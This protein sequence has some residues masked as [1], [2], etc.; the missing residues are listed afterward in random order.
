LTCR[1]CANAGEV[2]RQ[3]GGV[4][5]VDDA[6]PIQGGDTDASRGV[7]GA[8]ASGMARLNPNAWSGGERRGPCARE[9]RVSI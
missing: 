1:V 4:G 3:S 9:Y 5:R 6:V 2:V 7:R 8:D